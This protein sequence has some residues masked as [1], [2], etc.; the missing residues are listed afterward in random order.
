[1]YLCSPIKN[2]CLRRPGAF[3]AGA[4]WLQTY[5]LPSP[6]TCSSHFAAPGCAP[7]SSGRAPP[8]SRL[9]GVAILEQNGALASTPCAFR[10]QAALEHAYT[11]THP[12]GW[13]DMSSLRILLWGVWVAAWP[14]LNKMVLSPRRRNLRH[15]GHIPNILAVVKAVCCA[16]LACSVMAIRYV[17]RA[18]AI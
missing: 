13:T 3:R 4:P 10:F 18:S 12:D 11:H 2:Q 14:F 17:A 16:A 5:A 9:R 15:Q 8:C 1:M 6:N 7:R